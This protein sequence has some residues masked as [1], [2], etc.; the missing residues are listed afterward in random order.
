MKSGV[1]RE[2]LLDN[3]KV[4][5]YHVNVEKECDKRQWDKQQMIL[6]ECVIL[7]SM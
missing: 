2:V 4:Q 5:V 6:N 7:N 1:Q 3:Y